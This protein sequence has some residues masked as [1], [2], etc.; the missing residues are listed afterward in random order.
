MSSRCV[1]L[2]ARR[3]RGVEPSPPTKKDRQAIYTSAQAECCERKVSVVMHELLGEMPP[4][5]SALMDAS[6]SEPK[7]RRRRVNGAP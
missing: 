2:A 6:R 3:P 5:R 4:N 1:R 7:R